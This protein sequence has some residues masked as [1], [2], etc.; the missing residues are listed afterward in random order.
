MS[1]LTTLCALSFLLLSGWSSA[2]DLNQKI[3]ELMQSAIAAEAP[4]CNLGIMHKGAFLHKAGYGLANLELNVPLDG[5]Q[6]HRMASVSK[7]FTAMAV[8]ILAEQ[9]KIDLDQDIHTY[10]PALRDYG[11]TVTV[12]QMLGHTSGM[13]D[14]DLIADS[15]EGSKTANNTGLKSAAGGDFRLG[16]EDYLTISEFYDVVKRV[17][18]AMPPEQ[19]FQ[20]S[21]LAYFLLSMLVEEV[22]GQTLRDFSHEYVFKPLNMKHT[23]FSD[24]PVEIV[25]NRAYGY[26]Q[27]ED[28]SYVTDMTNLFWVGDGG[29][30]TNLDDLLRW[31]DNFLQPK[32]GKSPQ[33]LIDVMNTPN[34]DQQAREGV[35]YGNGQFIHTFKGYQ[36]YSHS[37]GWL[38]TATYFARY[39]ELELSFAMMC[40]DVSND[41]V[42]E[43]FNEVREAVFNTITNTE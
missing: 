6:V 34:S 24:N 42:F 28:G 29:L 33:A 39:P 21:N 37:G 41:Q 20:Y 36:A 9:G 3:D 19:K 12:R 22:S 8:R 14:Y 17:S 25:K 35:F 2:K 11:H 31:S 16:N 7:Q 32:I 23:F 26:K 4:G 10:L 43:A 1:R 18:L 40:N 38:G 15:Y 30:H 27:L 5:N 13:G